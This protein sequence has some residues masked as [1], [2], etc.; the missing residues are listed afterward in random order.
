M[1][2]MPPYQLYPSGDHA[3]TIDFGSMI[4][5]TIHTCVMAVFRHFQK[6]PVNGVLDIIPAYSTVT[7]VYDPLAVKKYARHATAYA[8]IEAMIL[9]ILPQVS[10]DNTSNVNHVRIPVCYDLS[11]GPDLEVLTAMHRLQVEELIHIHCSGTYRVFMLGFLPGFAYMGS[12][13]DRIVTPRL[14][15]PRTHVPAGSVGIA[16]KQTGIYPVASPGGW[17]L[18]GQTPLC[19][20]DPSKEKPCL[21]APGDEVVFYPV[22]L[23]EF[24]QLKRS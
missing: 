2:A 19:L 21:L 3:I 4:D 13:D 8:A 16:G 14:Q 10:I 9:A 18:I 7:L 17:Q 20:Y 24:K 5:L 15:E 12:V 23:A 22:S 1:P 6:N 11:L